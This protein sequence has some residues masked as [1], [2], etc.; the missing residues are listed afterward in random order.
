MGVP[1]TF[2]AT[3]GGDL[4]EFSIDNVVVRP[5]SSNR[6]FTT[7][8]L[9]LVVKEVKTRYGVELDGR[10][11]EAAWVQVHLKTII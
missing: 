5:M 7:N 6:V 2:T 9:S 8:T 3:G 10:V 1:L 4:F 11:A